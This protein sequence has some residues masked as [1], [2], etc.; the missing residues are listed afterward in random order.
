MLFF[1]HLFTVFFSDNSDSDSIMEWWEKLVS[2]IELTS[3]DDQRWPVDLMTQAV[4]S[5][6]VRDLDKADVEF[7]GFSTSESKFMD[8]QV[9]CALETVYEAI[10]DAGLDPV[11]LRGSKTGVFLALCNNDA[12]LALSAAMDTADHYHKNV[13]SEIMMAFDFRGGLFVYDTA[14]ASSMTASNEAYRAVKSGVIDQAIVIGSNIN[15]RP[16]VTAGFLDIGMLAKDG[17][18]KSFDASGDGFCRSEAVVSIL[19]QRKSVAK[20]IYATILAARTNTDGY[21]TEGITY[22]KVDTQ[23]RVMVETL[24]DARVHPS[25]IK[26]VEGH[27]TGTP[28]GDFVESESIFRTYCKGVDRQGQPLLV[29]CLKTNMG[30]GE[31][32]AGVAA[33]SKVCM[34]FER[35]ELPPNLHFK[36]PN[37][38]IPALMSGAIK[39]VTERMPFKEEIVGVSAFGFGGSNVH[40]ILKRNDK[41]PTEESVKS[42]WGVGDL[43]R[44]VTAFGRTEE[45]IKHVFKYI[46]DN[47]DKMT[48]DFFSLL[49]D[50]MSGERKR[51]MDYRG[52]AIFNDKMVVHKDVK[53]NLDQRPLWLV[54]PGVPK[55]WQPIPHQLMSVGPFRESIIASNK[56]TTD[57]F[58]INLTS[59]PT[60]L[61]QAMVVNVAVQVGLVDLLTALKV[62]VEGFIGHSIGDVVCGYCDGFLTKE[63]TLLTIHTIGEVLTKTSQAKS[64]EE[65]NGKL[66]PQIRD[67]L[68]KVIF[69]P[70]NG[71]KVKRKKS[72]RWV[73]SAVSPDDARSKNGNYITP[74]F[75]AQ[76]VTSSGDLVEK[77]SLIPKNAVVLEVSSQ[78][79]L[80]PILTGGFGPDITILSMVT[81]TDDI[82]THLMT[83]L[84]QLYASGKAVTVNNLYPKV[85]YPV[86]R[87]TLPISP[88]IKWRHDMSLTVTKYPEY[89]SLQGT[90]TYTIDLMDPSYEYLAGHA[91]DGRILCPAVEYLRFVWEIV[92]KTSGHR[93]YMNHPIE[94][95]GVKLQRAIMLSRDKVAKISLRY[96]R[97]TGSFESSHEGNVCCTGYAF[98]GKSD[99]RSADQFVGHVVPEPYAVTLDATSVY[100]ELQIRGYEYGPSFQGVVEAASDGSV[101]RIKWTGQWVSFVDSLLHVLI[102]AA[103]DR[104]LRIPTGID[105]FQCDPSVMM[106][107]VDKSTDDFGD[108]VVEVKYEKS[109]G[110]GVAPG[111]VISGLNTTVISRRKNEQQP[112][113][114]SYRFE[115]Y[116][117]INL[118]LSPCV[119]EKRASYESDC[120]KLMDII[121]GQ[122]MTKQDIGQLLVMDKKW[123]TSSEHSIINSLVKSVK[124]GLELE[125]DQ[126]N[127]RTMK[128]SSTAMSDILRDQ[129]MSRST[130]LSQ[131]IILSSWMESEMML[132]HQIDIIAENTAPS[133]SVKILEMTTI[134]STLASRVLPLLDSLLFPNPSYNVV[135]S[136]RREKLVHG[137][138]PSINSFTDWS[139]ENRNRVPD[140]MTDMDVVI[141]RDDSCDLNIDKESFVD[142][143]I[144]IPEMVKSLNANGFLLL[145]FRSGETSLESEIVKMVENGHRRTQ[146][147]SKKLMEVMSV[148]EG[149]SDLEM[150]SYRQLGL[151]FSLLVRKVAVSNADEVDIT[152]IP[153][154]LDSYKWID[155][156]KRVL[157]KSLT[158]GKDKDKGQKATK[159]HRRVWLTSKDA[160]SGLV[161]FF[162]CLRREGSDS[163]HVVRCY[164]NPNVSDDQIT[165]IPADI[166]RKDLTVN[167]V[168]DGGKLGSNRFSLIDKT[169]V[170]RPS[171]HAYLDIKTRGDMSS[172]RFLENGPTRYFDPTLDDGKITSKEIVVKVAYASINFKDVMIASGRLLPDASNLACQDITGKLGVEISGLDANGNR[173]FGYN[174]G[175]GL[176]TEVRVLDPV[177]MCPVPPTWSLEEAV[178][179]PVVYMTVFYGLLVRGKLQP[180]ET[181]LIHCGAGATG[182]AAINIAQ[183][184]GC[185]IFTTCSSGKRDFLK[186]TFGLEDWQIFDSRST[187]FEEHVLRATDGRGVDLVLNS[188]SGDKLKASINCL[189]D[190]GR[191]I[192]F[193]R[194]DMIVN[195]PLDV[196][197]F[198][199][200]KSFNVVVLEPDLDAV[201]FLNNDDNNKSSILMKKQL[202]GLLKKGITDGVVKPIVP[203]NVFDM[204]DVE[205]AFRFMA[206]GK[207]IGKVVVKVADEAQLIQKSSRVIETVQQTV[208]NPH[209]SYVIVG[210]LGGLGLELTQWMVT[211]GARKIVLTSRTGVKNNYQQYF[212]DRLRRMTPGLLRL[213]ISTSDVSTIEGCRDILDEAAKLG[214]I[215]SIFNLALVLKDSALE[216]Q[217]VETFSTV[218]ATKI[219]GTMFLDQL[220]RQMCPQ[221]DYFV[222]FSSL[223]SGLGNAGQTNYGYASSAMERICVKRKKDGLPALA[224]QWGPVGDV[225][226]VAEVVGNADFI[227]LG[228]IVPQKLSSCIETLDYFMLTSDEETVVSSILLTDTAISSSS[229]FG[230]RDK[231]DLLGVICHILGIRDR[232]KLNPTTTLTE[233]GLDSLMAVEIKQSLEREFDIVLTTQEIRNLKVKELKEMQE[234]ISVA[235]GG[236]QDGDG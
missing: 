149:C 135:H 148:L 38:N 70:G 85:E 67:S 52:F 97:A 210:G 51:G 158:G 75:F 195:S 73:S 19:F 162:N 32:A 99:L 61:A 76:T 146:S 171:S 161:G 226:Y 113:L 141:Y 179:T 48:N 7:F 155:Q 153:V 192:E 215:G 189:A 94:F 17:R 1:G 197:Q 109:T 221:L 3:I 156:V 223:T 44:L 126:N 103:D 222:C 196:S 69:Q 211:R 45:S 128:N 140:N 34:A 191:F 213:V 28:A 234:K 58:G 175:K 74:E 100:K 138:C 173:V 54:I 89:F 65:I 127:N 53:K 35:G 231:T 137:V 57:K 236:E 91:V 229:I 178:T 167:I 152:V 10:V 172:F 36:N 143:K 93:D 6:K 125:D 142:L 198:G 12:S 174:I 21:K 108:S 217:S 47:R 230:G 218:C 18:S 90:A 71:N 136:C 166:L 177:L 203:R 86:A 159:Q 31:G 144:L 169:E 176:A 8:L 77:L 24:Q 227:L 92:A 41:E 49:N 130:D 202:L 117:P 145:L 96:D 64:L 185:T 112:L 60:N 83:T 209:K 20:R 121:R 133:R 66:M 16:T 102:L 68:A 63:E 134:T 88:V 118:T 107:A 216:N 114:E 214:P 224:I 165:D 106:A 205:D 154:T 119:M 95:R 2:G 132:R 186:A 124:K 150:I 87:G 204:K 184:L 122:E 59:R 207:N 168:D 33:L 206:S 111:F 160:E 43:P 29:G 105:Y 190:H 163:G 80:E 170:K 104:A 14:C 50:V 27:V 11:T 37:P 129:L 123:P 56:Y 181:V 42:T 188:L 78:P 110:V 62:K 201:F 79:T 208:F 193:S 4:R 25:D 55:E 13:G 199:H 212:L 182:Q 235:D 22:P 98:L 232:S 40:A 26:Y 228:R 72:D 164:M 151:T 180:K 233:L 39:P 200:N 187:S 157:S 23:N 82:V 116:F 139:S 46:D 9:R 101:G 81:P 131:D 225:G 147:S 5:G 115:P 194:Y 220:S 30:H 219:T 120:R 84:G 15:L 183:S